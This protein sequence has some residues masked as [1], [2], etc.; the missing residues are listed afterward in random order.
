M[1]QV[2]SIEEM[3][4]LLGEVIEATRTMA[5]DTRHAHGGLQSLQEKVLATEAE[6]CQLRQDLD[7]ASAARHDPLTDALNR[8]GLMRFS[9]EIASMRRSD[10]AMCRHARY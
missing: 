5:A 10:A 4:P 3:A 8:K 9:H 7:Q 1:E 2:K 6:I